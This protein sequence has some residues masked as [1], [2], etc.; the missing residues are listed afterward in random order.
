V[1]R[2]VRELKNDRMIEKRCNEL[3]SDQA[4][5][6]LVTVSFLA[7]SENL[8]FTI[9]M[10]NCIPCLGMRG[11]KSLLFLSQR[12]ISG[13]FQ[14]NGGVRQAVIYP[15]IA[16]IRQNPNALRQD[17]NQAFFEYPKIMYRT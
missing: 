8:Q 11:V 14:R 15:L 9:Y 1:N 2:P 10:F 7:N 3:K 16:A 6:A 12:L 13:S 5:L 17:A 4:A